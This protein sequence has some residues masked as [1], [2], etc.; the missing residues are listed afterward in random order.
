MK[1]IKIIYEEVISVENLLSAWKEFLKGKSGKKDVEDFELNLAMNILALHRDL[2]T[3]IYTHGSY[4]HFTVTDPKRRDIHKASVRDRLLH[5]ALHRHLYPH[6]N[7]TFIHDS[8][9]SR[10]NKGMHKAMAQFSRYARKVSNNYTR[11]TWVL[12]CDIKKF[13]ASI[14]HKILFTILE[15]RIEYERIL[16]LLSQVVESF[17]TRA[18]KGLP[19]GNLT[20][21]LLVNIYMNEFD[22]FVEH[23]LKAQHYIRYADDFVL[24]HH[25]REYLLTLLPDINT[26]LT[27]KLKLTLHPNKVSISTVASGVDFLGWTHFPDHQTLRT[28]TKRRLFNTL[29][30]EPD[31]ATSQSYLGLLKHGNGWKIRRDVESR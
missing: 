1:K 23:K 27:S 10:K 9:A 2:T 15:K 3:H 28:T 19:L 4:Q 18:G 6:F 12:K 21:Q 26:F 11:T 20:S 30:S 24:L 17:W 13:F 8:Y 31:E 29:Q 5:H 7:T 16:W 25:D 14:D 22:Q